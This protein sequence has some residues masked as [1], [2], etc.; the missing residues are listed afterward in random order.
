MKKISLKPSQ[1]RNLF[2]LIPEDTVSGKEFLDGFDLFL[3]EMQEREEPVYPLSN[4]QGLEDSLLKI[5]KALLSKLK[6]HHY[7]A[8]ANS[9]RSDSVRDP[10]IM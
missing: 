5:K 7:F 4:Q 1:V 2:T 8:P 3:Q 6:Q 10:R 9:E